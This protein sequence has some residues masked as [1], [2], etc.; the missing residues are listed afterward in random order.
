[1]SSSSSSP[2]E[3][4]SSATTS[5]S[6]SASPEVVFTPYNEEEEEEE[7]LPPP[8]SSASTEPPP[9]RREI[10]F[11]RRNCKFFLILFT[12]IV[13]YISLLLDPIP[14]KIL[15]PLQVDPSYMLFPPLPDTPT[16]IGE[17]SSYF[18]FPV[19]LFILLF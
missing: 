2:P 3:S 6:A 18:I 11:P 1:M 14:A 17:Y 12:F 13:F 15:D 7:V 19:F 8:P 9:T 5:D 4:S 16:D 10:L